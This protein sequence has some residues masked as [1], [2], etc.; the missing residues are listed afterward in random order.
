MLGVVVL[1]I[2][3]IAFTSYQVKVFLDAEKEVDHEKI[4]ELIKEIDH[5]K[6]TS[7]EIN[8]ENVRADERQKSLEGQLLSIRLDLLNIDSDLK[9][10]FPRLLN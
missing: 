8:I 1:P 10:I 4:I 5:E 9:S 3:V 2:I 6:T 7:E